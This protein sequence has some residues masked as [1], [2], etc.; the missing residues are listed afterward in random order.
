MKNSE[1]QNFEDL[2]YRACVGLAVFNPEGRVFVGRRLGGPEHVDATH[3][4]QMPQGGI[5]ENEDPFE[6]ALRELYEETNI[7]SIKRLGEIDGWLKY[8]IPRGIAGQ[9]WKGKYRG[10][11]QKWFALRFTGDESEIDVA[12]PGGGAHKPEFVEWRWE[13]LENTPQLIVPFKRPV[14]DDVVRGFM[15]FANGS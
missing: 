4:W 6:A 8:D 2:P 3:S 7:R 5:D 15:G 10:Q 9:A 12:T 14:Y 11:K 1:K 13:R